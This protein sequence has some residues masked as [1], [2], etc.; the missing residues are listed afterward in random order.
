[1]EVSFEETEEEGT[2][3]LA[4]TG[5]VDLASA[6]ELR[7]RL[8]ALAGRGSHRVVVDLTSVSFIDST[9]LGVLVSALKRFRSEGGDLRLAVDRPQ[10]AK[11]LEITGLDTVFVVAPTAAEAAR[12]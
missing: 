1:V 11:V 4:V 2:V 5:E 3:I 8:L 9:G 7:Q 12:R 6:P 10:I